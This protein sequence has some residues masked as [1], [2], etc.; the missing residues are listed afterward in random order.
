MNSLRIRRG[1]LTGA[2]VA[3]SALAVVGVVSSP[4]SAA[5]YRYNGPGITGHAGYNSSTNHGWVC[6]DDPDGRQ[7][8]AVWAFPGT[9]WDTTYRINAPAHGDGCGGGWFTKHPDGVKVC[10]HQSN[11]TDECIKYDI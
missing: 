10:I 1:A 7:V 3:A 9:P 2:A 11:R 4:A 5:T 6:D 8:Y